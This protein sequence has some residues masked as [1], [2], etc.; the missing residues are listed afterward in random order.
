MNQASKALSRVLQRMFILDFGLRERV[1]LF[2]VK[3]QE[4]LDLQVSERILKR[5]VID[6]VP[7][8]DARR[9][10]TSWRYRFSSIPGLDGLP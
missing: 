1:S 6:P 4:G 3:R 2:M 8:I 7:S 9:L 10:A 5:Y